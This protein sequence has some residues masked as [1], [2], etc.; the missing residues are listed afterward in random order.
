MFKTRR[1]QTSQPTIYTIEGFYQSTSI[2]GPLSFP[3]RF[4]IPN[5]YKNEQYQNL[6]DYY[7]FLYSLN[8]ATIFEYFYLILIFLSGNVILDIFRARRDLSFEDI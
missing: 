1:V 4:Q 6:A 2:F 7:K 5:Y 3:L 8:F